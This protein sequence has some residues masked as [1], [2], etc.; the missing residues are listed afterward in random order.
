MFQLDHISKQYHGEFAVHDVSFQLGAGL[1]FIIGPSGSG[2]TTLLKILSGME[3]SFDGEVRYH[4][5]SMKALTEAER[6]YFYNHIFGFIWQNFNLLE[7]RTVWE[8]LLL[9]GYV[10]QDMDEKSANRILNQLHMGEFRNQKVRLL[11]GGQKQRV[12]IARELMKDPQV[13]IADEPTSALDRDSAQTIMSVLRSLSKKKTVIVVTHDTSLIRK[14]DHVFELDKGQLVAGPQL[15]PAAEKAP[16]WNLPYGLSFK[17]AFSLSFTG[18]KRKIGRFVIAVLSVL[19][20]GLLILA[21]VSGAISDNGQEEFQRLFETYGDALTDIGIYGSF[22]NASDS[23]Q[24]SSDGQNKGEVNQN[25]S[26]LYDQYAEDERVSFVSYLQSFDD[27]SVACDEKAYKIEGSGSVPVINKMVAGHM[28]S[29]DQQEVVV[30]ESLV[31]QMGITPEEALGKVMDFSGSVV[32]WVDNRP[33]YEKVSIRVP[34]AGVM[35]TNITLESQGE[36]YQISVDDSFL[37]SKPALDQML[38]A[39]GKDTS[40][41]NFL[42]RAKSPQDMIAI[43]DELNARGVVPL[44]RFELIEDIVRLNQSTGEQSAI[45]N[46]V[47]C[48]LALVLTVSTCLLTGFMRKK[49]YAIYKISGY[50]TKHFFLLHVTETIFQLFT[51]VFLL[52]VTAP[53]WGMILPVNVFTLLS[54][55]AIVLLLSVL[56]YGAT[57]ISFMKVDLSNIL[58][59]GDL[60]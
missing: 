55:S 12:A 26:G 43:K 42:I 15:P 23:D 13:I 27:V 21:P 44:G 46:V 45:A 58:K 31:K 50:C 48:V 36:T 40:A 16:D 9:P 37:F 54:G 18:I 22:L 53:V 28:P 33:V 4:G 6:G 35:D 11:S 39:I 10:K 14:G 20:A 30:P 3:Q 5:K 51:C 56:S 7:D 19:I 49:E 52:L 38:T 8:N 24:A 17:N 59:A 32:K 57:A 2:K 1:N 60:S 25:I 29:N 41:M 47:V 34:I